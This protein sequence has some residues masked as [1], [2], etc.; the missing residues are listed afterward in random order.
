[1]IIN[2]FQN[3]ST[4]A[5]TEIKQADMVHA[6]WLKKLTALHERLAAQMN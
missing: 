3:L 5:L 6:Y 2:W 4:A 1:M